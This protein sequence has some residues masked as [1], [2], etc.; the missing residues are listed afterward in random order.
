MHRK[1][2]RARRF[3]HP[4]KYLKTKEKREKIPQMAV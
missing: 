4:A 3:F 1:R 2:G